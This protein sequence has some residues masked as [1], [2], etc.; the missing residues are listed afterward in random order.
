MTRPLISVVV[1]VYNGTNFLAEALES[2]VRQTYSPVEL[3]VVN[4]GSTDG[5]GVIAEGFVGAKVIHQENSGLPAARNVGVAASSGQYL[6]FLDHDDIWEPTKLE[7]QARV[8]MNETSV[9]LV[10]CHRRHRIEGEA[11]TW[12]RGPTDDTPV[13]GFVPSCWLVRRST[14]DEV[15]PFDPRFRDSEDYEWLRR[16]RDLGVLDVMLEDVL[17]DYR[18]HSANKTSKVAAGQRDMFMYLRESVNRR[19]GSP[20]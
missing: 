2:V 5:S 8:L 15:G 9:G 4:D 1:P 19:R 11:P 17:I 18:V 14:F 7:L 13:K 16:A 10:L 6:A 3:I 20:Q 12:F